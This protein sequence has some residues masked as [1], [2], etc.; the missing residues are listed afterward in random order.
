MENKTLAQPNRLIFFD[1]LRYLMVLLVLVFH[2]GSSY[3]SMVAFWPYHDPQPAEFVDILMLLLDV[4]MMSILFFIA[5][6]FALSSL[7]KRS[8]GEFLK[9]KFKQLGI[10]WLVITVLVL[11]VLDYVHYFTRSVSGGLLPRSYALHWWMSMKKIAEFSVGPLRMSE[12][13][14]MTEHYYQ[15][16]MWFL[17]LL[18]VFFVIFWLLYEFW[19]KRRPTPQ[20]RTTSSGSVY[21]A[22]ALT[23]LLNVLVFAL[24][25][26]LTSSLDNPFYMGWFS[27]GNLVQFESA[28]L[29]F[30]IPCFGLGVYAYS[31][32]WFVNGKDFGKPWVWGVICFLLMGIN[33][34]IGRSM[35]R[36]VE[37]SV[38]L[39]MAFVTLYP[40]WTFSFLGMFTAFASRRWNRATF[41]DR[42]LAANSYNM[43]L[44]H[45]PF[46]MMLPLLLSGM[47]IPSLGKFG[48]VAL[49][50][51]LASYGISKFVIKPASRL[52]LIGL[53]GLNIILAACY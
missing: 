18:L 52:L 16:Y 51:I 15:R 42:E 50:T 2:S 10:P 44:A 46:A 1:N 28:K 33:M 3:G 29:A 39:Q 48:I 41:F 34:L 27:L 45:Y 24:V 5:G 12:Y 8:G 53:I 31:N 6:Y 36:A 49:V 17:S 23:S 43:Y 7:K 13:L 40:L 4:F 20:A 47:E 37:P 32:Q 11:P 21:G 22:L 35:A 30:Y 19:M 38:G 9:D 25:K 14:D 26:F